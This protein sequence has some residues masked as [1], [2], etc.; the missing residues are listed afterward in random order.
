MT[1]KNDKKIKLNKGLNYLFAGNFGKMQSL[2][3][4]I[5]AAK[6]YYEINKN[7]NFNLIGDGNIK[8]KLQEMINKNKIKNVYLHNRVSQD[9][10]KNVY[11]QADILILP[12]K[13]NSI[14]NKTIPGKLQTYM[15]IAKPILCFADGISK[16]IVNEANC[17]FVCDKDNILKLIEVFKL[18]DN[19]SKQKLTEFS[20]NS[21]KYYKLHFR[22][23]I[24]YKKINALI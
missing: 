23:E 4:L 5:Q 15:S 17:G 2:E 7:V 24:I 11:E 20:K 22:D 3:I 12:L 14:I 10:M 6:Q 16:K 19:S 8:V 1:N 21:L 13:K 18:F 9:E